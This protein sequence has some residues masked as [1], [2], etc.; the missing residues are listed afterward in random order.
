MTSNEKSCYI[1]FRNIFFGTCVFV[2]LVI[3][4]LYGTVSDF[5]QHV[6]PVY[7]SVLQVIDF[8]SKNVVRYFTNFDVASN[9]QNSSS[10][11][12]DLLLNGSGR[13]GTSIEGGGKTF[14]W[15]PDPCAK[16][17]RKTGVE[18]ILCMTPPKFLP[19]YKNPCYL[20]GSTL[21]CLPY[22]HLIGICKSGTSDLFKRLHLHP[23]IVENKGIFGKEIWYWSWQRLQTRSKTNP[24]GPPYGKTLKWF[25][26]RFYPE[27]IKAEVDAHGYHNKITGHGDP[28]DVWDRAFEVNMPQNDP[29]AEELVWTTPYSVYHINPRVKLMLMLRDP[30]DRLYS[31]YFHSGAGTSSE[32]FHKHILISLDIWKSCLSKHSLRH[33]IYDNS[34]RRA[35]KAPIYT[36]FYIVHILEWLKVFPREQ[37]L[38]FRNEDYKREMKGTLS[39]IFK[40]LNVTTPSETLYTKMTSLP[41]FYETKAKAKAGPMKLETRK[42]LIDLYRPFT[43]ELA[44]FLGD[45]KF[46]FKDTSFG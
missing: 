36:S 2:I 39:E 28:M 16:P 45:E 3:L 23:E 18:D 32:S 24:R 46:G 15:M 27:K 25:T 4:G 43:E 21:R 20:D 38:I 13:N 5:R 1:Y 29:D 30:V 19:D 26:D 35:L 8:S 42:L 31:H 7:G 40:F 10:I 9:Y 34:V 12:S 17:R 22:F 37:L 11:L 6:T 14:P 44:K 41:K 33:C